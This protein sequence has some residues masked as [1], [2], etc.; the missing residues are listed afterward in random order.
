MSPDNELL[1]LRG[2]LGLLQR[3]KA[4]FED[5]L[6]KQQ[7]P[8]SR[9][10]NTQ[11]SQP[12][13]SLPEDYP[14]TPEAA[15]QGI[16]AA[17]SRG[18]FESFLTN[19]TEPGVPHDTYAQMFTEQMRSNFLGTE[20]VSIGQPTNWLATSAVLKWFVP[21]TIR[22][23]DGTQ[24]TFRLSVGQHVATQRYYFDGGL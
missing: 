22:F 15:T 14:K 9:N 3:Q 16:F 1:R 19:F 23:A 2:E 12:P 10:A 17:L 11:P 5:L 8:Q 20:I 13:S 24:K 4:D 18:D 6:A 21:Y 7:H